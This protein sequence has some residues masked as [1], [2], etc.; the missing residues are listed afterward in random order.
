MDPELWQLTAG[1]FLNL[2]A[3]A[4]LVHLLPRNLGMPPVRRNSCRLAALTTMAVIV[5]EV[6]CAWLDTA[7]PGAWAANRGANAL[8]FSLSAAIPYVLA[9]A[10]D[11]RLWR[12][13]HLVALPEAALAALCL[14][15]VWTGWL[16]TV[17]R[18]NVYSRG[19]LFWVYIAVFL[20]GVALL[21]AANQR[22]ASSF[23]LWERAYLALLYA[24]FLFGISLQL[25]WPQLHTS[26]QCVTL[27]LLLYYIFQ[28]ELEFRYDLL[29]GVLNRGCFDSAAAKPLPEGTLLAVFDLD[30]FKRINDTYGHQS[31]DEILRQSAAVLRE[32]FAA[33]GPCYR[34]GGDEFAVLGQADARALQAASERMVARIR[35]LREQGSRLPNISYGSAFLCRDEPFDDL[36]RRA[37][38]QMYAYKLR[39]SPRARP[40]G[41]PGED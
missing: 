29:T 14:A 28:R 5:S 1:S 12:W 41:A 13:R 18:D 8:G 34:I 30:D 17:S 9:V 3:L 37:D 25:L 27:S 15:S 32:A 10:Y 19:P 33:V 36:F 6:T 39:Q 38:R 4:F 20:G 7:G 11:E 16:F 21:A 2:A 23:F 24:L 22:Q 35:V 40:D 26:W 31:G